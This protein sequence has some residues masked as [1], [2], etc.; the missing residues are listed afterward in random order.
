MLKVILIGDSIRMGYEPL[1][2]EKLAGRAEVWGP[3]ENGGDSTNVLAHLDEWALDRAADVIHF[4]CGLHDLKVLPD[5][6]HQVA[7]EEYARN[8]KEIVERLTSETDARLIWATSTPVVDDRHQA[9]KGCDFQRFAKDV[10]T[11]NRQALQ[12]VNA[13]GI[14]VNDLHG[15]VERAGIESCVGP[16]GVHMTAKGYRILAETVASILPTRGV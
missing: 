13:A 5:G 6:A 2:R 10:E 8:L 7:L 12:I 4:N 15:V 9:R 3:E 16:D 14:R 1:V 11:Y